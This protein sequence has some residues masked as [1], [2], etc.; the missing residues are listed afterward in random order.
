M[1]NSLVLATQN[2]DKVLEIIKL[3]RGCCGEVLSLEAFPDVPEVVEDGLTLEENAVK[4]A[5]Q[6]GEY[7]GLPAVADD[8]G[9]E[10]DALGGA[11]GVFSSR[12]AGQVATY[13]ENVAKL[14][15]EL[16]GVPAEKR[17]ARFRTVVAFYNQGK[18]QT[19]EG[20]CE[21]MISSEPSGRDGFGYDPVFFVPGRGKTFAEMD[22][23]EKNQIS[24]RGVAFQRFRLLLEQS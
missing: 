10:V 5:R 24:H 8:T 17:T 6:I 20:V 18:V 11:P 1:L 21:G 19:V 4:K 7:T 9:L 3:L 22:L 2:K 23:S 13:A 12:F 16:A 15:S 14:L